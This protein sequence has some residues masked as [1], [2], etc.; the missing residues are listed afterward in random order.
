MILWK[1]LG[2]ITQTSVR[3]YDKNANQNLQM[4]RTRPR[5]LW[6]SFMDFQQSTLTLRADCAIV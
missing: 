2:E 3:P 1:E 4:L 5:V 6:A